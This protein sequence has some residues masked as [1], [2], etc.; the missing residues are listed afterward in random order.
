MDACYGAQLWD[1][2]FRC[3]SRRREVAGNGFLTGVAG[4]ANK[5]DDR[6][7][8]D[9]EQPGKDFERR[10]LQTSDLAELAVLLLKV[11]RLGTKETASSAPQLSLASSKRT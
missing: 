8:G 4:D 2:D 10:R 7:D 1:E 5:D 11:E 9:D 3:P 6:A